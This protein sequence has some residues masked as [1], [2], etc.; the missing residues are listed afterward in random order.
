MKGRG[1][2]G[3]AE[4]AEVIDRLRD[5]LSQL[6]ISDRRLASFTGLPVMTHAFFPGGNGL[7]QGVHAIQLP[8]RGVLV[9]GSNFG[10]LGDFVN[11]KGE[12]VVLDERPNRTWR[13]LR[14]ILVGS[15]IDLE[16]CFF[17]NAWP[18]LHH[19]DSNL[20]PIAD[21]LGDPGLMRACVR[22]FAITLAEIRPRMIIAL[23]T[24]PAAFLG[25]IWPEQLGQWR[26]Y[27]ISAL[28]D[29][30]MAAV[31]LGNKD[32]I[33]V[34]ITHPSMPNAWRRRPP[35]QGRIGEVQLL[36]EA[37]NHSCLING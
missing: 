10:S 7:W 4:A 36:I 32:A 18:F 14:K 21:W 8:V 28:D 9:L 31:S 2:S 29:L 25:S 27:N 1:E 24:G 33:C 19:G 12:L 11:E 23:G 30:P 20:G 13:P 22:F 6:E 16:E 17:T 26:G 35:Y 5:A 37:H 34:A 15:G 3:V